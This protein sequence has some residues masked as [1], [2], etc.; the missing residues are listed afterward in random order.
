MDGFARGADLDLDPSGRP[1]GNRC[2]M[3]YLNAGLKAGPH[4]RTVLAHEYTHAVTFSRKALRRRPPGVRS[5][6]EE[7]GWLDEAIAHLVED[8]FGFS[9]SN[10]DYRVSAYLTQP[11][12]YRL[13]VDD[14]FSADLFRSHGNRGAT[15]LFLR[16]CVDRH[17]PGLLDAL[18]RS[19][20]RGVENLEAA[21]GSTFP[22][23]FRRWTV[24]L[25]LSGLDGLGGDEANFPPALFADV[26]AF[27]KS[28][29]LHRVAHAGEAAGAASVRDAVEILGA[30]R[31]GHGVRA[32]EDPAL[33]SLLAE[34]QI[35]LEVC[36]TSNF[37]TGASMRDVLHPIVALDAAGVRCAIDSDD[38]ALFRTTVSD[39]Y[40]LVRQ[41]LGDDAVLRL[42]GNA[43]AASFAPA[44]TKAAI[45]AELAAFASQQR[46]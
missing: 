16:W 7:E 31:I 4:L 28:E 26:F 5:P 10:I 19:D 2:D 37:L 23:L 42:A 38:P 6:S 30:E 1:F 29:G 24:A 33:L 12:R 34:R 25:Y 43:I 41:W 44:Q 13:V 18:V 8:A 14:Y 3:V 15:Y 9:R 40:A 11:E 35:A 32:L 22:D 39:E 36:P 46:A 17:G 21:T 45:A 20:L 27:A